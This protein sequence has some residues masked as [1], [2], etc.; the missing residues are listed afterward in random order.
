MI[1]DEIHRTINDLKEKVKELE[2]KI[3]YLEMI[4]EDYPR[5]SG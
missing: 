2:D 1:P 4:E 5:N 3:G